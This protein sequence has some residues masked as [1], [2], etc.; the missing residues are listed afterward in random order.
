MVFGGGASGKWLSADEVTR[1]GPSWWDEYS[2]KRPQTAC[3][4]SPPCE[5]TVRSWPSQWEAGRRSQEE[6]PHQD[7]TVPTL[8]TQSPELWGISI[9][10]GS[11]LSLWCFGRAAWA[12]TA[13][14]VSKDSPKIGWAP[15]VLPVPNTWK[16]TDRALGKAD[17]LD[18]WGAQRHCKHPKMLLKRQN[19]FLF[20]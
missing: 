12:K 9:C 11:P 6:G 19:I 18:N 1:V 14:S 8:R 3:S 17:I 13:L 10:C 20:F 15:T 2:Y 4:L 7:R 16:M 5:G